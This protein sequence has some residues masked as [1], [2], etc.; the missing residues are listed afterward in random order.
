M[1]YLLETPH[2]K[3]EC[4][5][6]L[7]GVLAQGRDILNNFYWGCGAGNHTGYA[8]VDAKDGKE[9]LGLIPDFVRGKARIV[10]LEKCSPEQIKS[11]HKAA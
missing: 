1:K 9:A 6:E 5:R 7:D 10:Q 11:F 2:T 4:L 3:E 8:I